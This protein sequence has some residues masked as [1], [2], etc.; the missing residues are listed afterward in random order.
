MRVIVS[1]TDI[2]WET[3]L[4][5]YRRFLLGEIAIKVVRAPTGITV[6]VAMERPSVDEFDQAS[7]SKL[8]TWSIDVIEERLSIGMARHQ[9]C[10]ITAGRQ[11]NVADFKARHQRPMGVET[12][13]IASGMCR[14]NVAGKLA[15][16][17][18]WIDSKGAAD[19]P[20]NRPTRDLCT[21]G[22]FMIISL[23]RIRSFGAPDSTPR[24]EDRQHEGDS[25]RGG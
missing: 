8:G 18:R 6:C 11:H 17:L 16:K 10:A 24:F 2:E 4:V 14:N 3:W 13:W 23:H 12:A 19:R 9:E 20:E 22:L 1:I 7:L 21:A 25:Q 5:T 15:M